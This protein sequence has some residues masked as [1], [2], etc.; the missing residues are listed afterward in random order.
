MA[1]S[2]DKFVAGP[3]DWVVMRSS[4][5]NN[6]IRVRRRRVAYFQSIGWIEGWD[7]Y[8][9]LY[10]GRKEITDRITKKMADV[11][12]KIKALENKV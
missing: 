9:D 5:T 7:Y 12:A 8:R 2:D 6:L 10:H 3:E 4:V 11:K 1:I